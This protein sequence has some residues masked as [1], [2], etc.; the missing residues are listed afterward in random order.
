MDLPSIPP[1]TPAVPGSEPDDAVLLEPGGPGGPGEPGG[2]AAVSERPD[3]ALSSAVLEIEAHVAEE[4]WDRPARLF[5]LVETAHL[6]AHEPALVEAMGLPEQPRPGALTSVE[7]ELAAGE[8]LERQLEQIGWPDGVAGCAAVVERFVLPPGVGEDLPDDD[9]AQAEFAA[10]HPDRQEVRIVAA[11]LRSGATF[12]ALRLRSHDE[13]ASVVGGTD[14]VPG[15]LTL[16]RDTL[17]LDDAAAAKGAS[18][19][20]AEPSGQPGQGAPGTMENPDPPLVDP[21]G[22]RP[23][24]EITP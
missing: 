16:L 7:Q 12:C 22:R 14:L 24:E 4:G 23:D 1:A 5:A 8:V 9:A 21:R 11:A 6:V 19:A 17:D 18:A 20:A 2:V 3:P 15:L 10:S 13:A